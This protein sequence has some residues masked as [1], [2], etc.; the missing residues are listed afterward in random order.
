MKTLKLVL[1]ALILVITMSFTP[2]SE[3]APGNRHIVLVL[4]NPMNQEKFSVFDIK[5]SGEVLVGTNLD[6]QDYYV[7]D[8]IYRIEGASNDKFYHK[9]IVVINN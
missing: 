9:K 3:Y 2:M 5:Q 8:G 7:Q 1:S 4:K 6:S